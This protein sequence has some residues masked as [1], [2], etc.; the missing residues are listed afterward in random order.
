MPAA[1]DPIEPRPARAAVWIPGY[2]QWDGGGYVWIAGAWR[3]PPAAGQ[4]WQPARWVVIRGGG[5]VF[6]PGGW[7]LH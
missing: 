1:A 3:I 4:T 6:A 2:W 5:A 7:R